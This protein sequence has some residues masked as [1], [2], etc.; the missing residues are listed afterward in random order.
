M[1]FGIV[2]LIYFASIVDGLRFFFFIVGI[3]CVVFAFISVPAVCDFK[4]LPHFK[5]VNPVKLFKKLFSTGV[6]FCLLCVLM[7]SEKQV[8]YMSAAY[9]GSTAIENIANSPEVS[10]V[11]LIVNHKMDEYIKE[12]HIQPVKQNN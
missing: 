8:Y 4:D 11:R 6:I 10:K 1:A 2:L 5:N 7:P 3:S 12:N 9:I